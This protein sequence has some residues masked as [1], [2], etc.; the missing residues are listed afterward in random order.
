MQTEGILVGS[1]LI[2][3]DT[4]FMQMRTDTSWFCINF[5]T[6]AATLEIHTPEPDT[7][8]FQ[9]SGNTMHTFYKGIWCGPPDTTPTVR[10][11][12]NL[13]R[14]AGGP[15]LTG[16]WKVVS[17]GYEAVSGM[18]SS[19]QKDFYER[20]ARESALMKRFMTYEVEFS[21]GK[22][23]IH[24]QGDVAGYDVAKWNGEDQIRTP[25]SARYDIE[26][27]AVNHHTVRFRGRKTGE[28]VTLEFIGPY[29]DERYSSDNPDHP[30]YLKSESA[31]K[32]GSWFRDFLEANK[33]PGVLYKS[34]SYPPESIPHS[35]IG[36]NLHPKSP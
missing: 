13:Q 3:D 6:G 15:G 1:Y 32:C 24:W 31:K 20:Q 11:Y 27:K 25:D 29:K 33:H 18:M 14:V 22:Y 9:I 30:T 28:T 19:A 4:L 34:R 7:S 36:D 16:R 17:S 12:S 5:D 8:W 10:V 2:S 26:V 35:F 21:E 23:W